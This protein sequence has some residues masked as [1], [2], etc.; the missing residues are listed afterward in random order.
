[1]RHPHRQHPHRQ[2]PHRQRIHPI[3]SKERIPV[4]PVPATCRPTSLV[5]HAID[6][7]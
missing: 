7:S 1:M 5:C 2:H 4:R 6:D 3:L